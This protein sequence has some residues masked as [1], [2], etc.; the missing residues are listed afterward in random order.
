MSAENDDV[1]VD[2]VAW[3]ASCS[4]DSAERWKRLQVLEQALEAVKLDRG[5]ALAQQTGTNECMIYIADSFLRG[6][7]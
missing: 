2:L 1:N 3:L 7:G 6:R 4:L 5:A